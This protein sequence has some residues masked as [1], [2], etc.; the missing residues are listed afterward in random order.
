MLVTHLSVSLGNISP[1]STV[2]VLADA[3]YDAR[4]DSL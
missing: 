1:I 3:I 2:S 4:L